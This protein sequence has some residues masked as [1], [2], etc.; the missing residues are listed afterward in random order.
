MSVTVQKSA[1]SDGKFDRVNSVT[2]FNDFENY[3]TG[4]DGVTTLADAGGTAAQDDTGGTD[5]L[6]VTTAATGGDKTGVVTTKAWFLFQVIQAMWMAVY[7]KF[8]SNTTRSAGFMAGFWSTKP[9]SA[10]GTTVPTTSYSGA[11]IYALSGDTVWRTQSS[12]ATTKSNHTSTLAIIEGVFHQF[13]IDIVNRDGLSCQITYSVDGQTLMDANYPNQPI[14]DTV[15]YANVL[16]MQAGMLML[17]AGA[18]E[19]GYV[20]YL[21]AAKARV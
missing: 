16:K 15:L 13:R 4:T 18:A 8:S 1:G 11:I 5:N 19:V 3:A 10:S 6:L 20:D 17:S 2:Y 21:T 9:A 12:N 14:I 7:A